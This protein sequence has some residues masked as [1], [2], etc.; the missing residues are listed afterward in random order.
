[1]RARGRSLALSGRA[2]EVAASSLRRLQGVSDYNAM[3]VAR[4][5][6]CL[7]Q[8][9]AAAREQRVR[10]RARQRV[11]IA[12]EHLVRVVVRVRVRARARVRARVRVRVR[13]KG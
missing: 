8:R 7:A 9:D 1:M 12:R 3:Q 5:V 4:Q 2:H 11:E 13:V 10:V 6:A